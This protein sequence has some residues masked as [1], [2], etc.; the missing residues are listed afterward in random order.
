MA[1]SLWLCKMKYC[2]HKKW[3]SGLSS[4]SLYND[5]PVLAETGSIVIQQ[6]TDIWS[7]ECFLGVEGLNSVLT[8]TSLAGLLVFYPNSVFW[9]LKKPHCGR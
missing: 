1:V 2:S 7:T 3:L 8:T 6:H 5:S 9:P 4:A